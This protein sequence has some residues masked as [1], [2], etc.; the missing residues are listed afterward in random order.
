[1]NIVQFS[2]AEIGTRVDFMFGVFRKSY[3]STDNNKLTKLYHVDMD[4]IPTEVLGHILG[5]LDATN[6]R[7]IALVNKHLHSIAVRLLFRTLIIDVHDTHQLSRLLQTLSPNVII[8]V[9]D[10]VIRGRMFIVDQTKS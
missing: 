6:L 7:S 3:K 1:M 4:S 10:M 8:S 5:L 9:K 2:P